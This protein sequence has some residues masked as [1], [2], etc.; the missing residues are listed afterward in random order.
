MSHNIK[1]AKCYCI[2]C[3]GIG[4][5]YTFPNYSTTDNCDVS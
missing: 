5:Y 2:E 3:V 4:S 1:C